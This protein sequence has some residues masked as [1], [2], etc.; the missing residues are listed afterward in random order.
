MK[1]TQL[2]GNVAGLATLGSQIYVAAVVKKGGM[3]AVVKVGTAVAGAVGVGYVAG[4]GVQQLGA[5]PSVQ[6]A[7]QLA[8][9]MIT[10]AVLH[11]KLGLGELG[12]E[13]NNSQTPRANRQAYPRPR[14]GRTS[15][16][17]RI[18]TQL[19]MRPRLAPFLMQRRRRGTCRV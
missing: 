13:G 7:T 17:R 6:N 1:I 19:A 15:R 9:T 18:P 5:P 2:A 3:W 14:R 10:Y 11:S 16:I 12:T 8:A 4:K